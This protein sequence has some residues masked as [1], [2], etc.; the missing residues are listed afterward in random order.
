[1]ITSTAL[2]HLNNISKSFGATKAVKDATISFSTGQIIGLVGE[3]GAGKSTLAKIIAGV[4]SADSGSISLD[5][6]LVNFKSPFEALNAGVAMMAQEIMLIPE[7]TVEVNIFLGNLPS[8]GWFP[9][10]EKMREE[11]KKLNDLTGFALKPDVKVSSLRLA[12]Q[13][14]VEIMR[15]IA[16]NSKL[17]IMDEP[18]ASL[19]ADEVE[20]LHHTV[21][22]LVSRGITVLL[23]SHFLE[24]VLKLT[25]TV[26]IMRDGEI[27]RSGP[28]SD[29]TVE[30][31]VSGMVGRSLETRY[32]EPESRA[33]NRVLLKVDGLTNKVLRNISFEIREGEILGLAGLIGSGRSEIARAIFGA[34]R[35]SSGKVLVEGNEISLKSPAEVISSGVYMIPENRKEQG[36]F[37]NASSSDNIL[38]STLKTRSRLSFISKKLLNKIASL[39]AKDIDLRFNNINQLAVSLSGGNQQKLLFGR[40]VEVSPKI[41]IVD[42]PTRGVDIAAKR[43]IHKILIEQAKKGTAILFISSELEEVL[44]VCDRVLVINRGSIQSEF[45]RPFNQTSVVAAFFGQITGG[46]SD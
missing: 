39:L 2:V 36:L 42:E 7:A 5:G 11:F 14:K 17:I 35:I 41:L 6:S 45:K 22:E 4:Y 20:R 21:K 3:N 8:N 9:D 26:I 44:G 38:I 24:E 43:A 15:S 28:T 1:M 32:F 29:E 46:K 27:V 16:R 34:D 25:E 23:I 40:A 30:T 33:S 13:Q 31:L 19:T 37:L 18:S 10:N 12:D